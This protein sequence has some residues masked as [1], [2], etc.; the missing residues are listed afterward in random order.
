MPRHD[1]RPAYAG[2]GLEQLLQL[3]G[4]KRA[5][6]RDR[7]PG[8]FLLTGSANLLL[9]PRVTESLAGRMEIAQ[10]QPL[11]KAEKERKP[12]EFLRAL[13]EGSLKPAIKGGS[14]HDLLLYLRRRNREARDH[15]PRLFS[16]PP[17]L[18]L[19]HR[20]ELSQLI[21][22]SLDA[23]FCVEALARYR[24][25]QI[26]NTN[27]GGKF[28][29]EELL[30]DF[31]DAPCDAAGGGLEWVVGRRSTQPHDWDCPD[32]RLI[33]VIQNMADLSSAGCRTPA[34]CSWRR[35][36]NAWSA[37]R[38]PQHRLLRRLIAYNP[39]NWVQDPV[40]PGILDN[41]EF[42]ALSGYDV[43]LTVNSCQ[44][45][46]A[47]RL[48]KAN[49]VEKLTGLTANQL[50]EWTTLRRLTESDAKPSGPGS[51][52]R[53]AWRM[54]L[55][56]GLAEAQKGPPCRTAF[57]ARTLFAALSERL[58]NLLHSIAGAVLIIGAKGTLNLL[59]A[60]EVHASAMDVLMLR[61][62]PH[63]DVLSIQQLPLFPARAVT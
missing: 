4:I 22:V 27:Q 38:A 40:W 11:T 32:R 59:P 37:M 60:E 9:V 5:V 16:L 15:L 26:F 52:A 2:F 19:L 34:S 41:V 24:R 6:D 48:V 10:L 12:G 49:H 45:E 36:T 61:P 20:A 25:P 55:L 39:P 58:T 56:L 3:P 33:D 42:A 51:R 53:Y 31:D 50:H 44:S 8:R 13:L 57:A 14:P 29:G 35:V 30:C 23:G 7:H 63:L 43:R 54:V 47:M 18:S 62:D 28:T 1:G 17:T 46:G 21:R